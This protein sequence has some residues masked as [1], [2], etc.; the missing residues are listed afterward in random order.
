[1]DSS[2]FS[3]KHEEDE[4]IRLFR[5][6]YPDIYDFV[7]RLIDRVCDEQ[8]IRK[9]IEEYDKETF[10]DIKKMIVLR[11]DDEDT[12]R[13]KEEYPEEFY[14]AIRKM[15]HRKKKHPIPA[16]E[17]RKITTYK[18]GDFIEQKDEIFDVLGK[19]G[20]GNKRVR[21]DGIHEYEIEAIKEGGMGRVLILSRASDDFVD[22]FV[23]SLIKYTPRLADKLSLI[24]RGILAAKTFK[25]DVII[26]NNKALFE[27]ELNIWIN[28]NATNVAKLL[29]IVFINGKLFALMPYYSSN[30]R[31]I[32]KKGPL[33]IDDAKIIII[34]IIRGLYE[35]HKQYGI[36]HQDLKPEN[37]LISH[38]KDNTYFFV[39]DWGIAN[40]QKRY[41]PEFLSKELVNSYA[42]TMTGMG[43]LPYMSPERFIKYSS[44]MTAD[45]FSLGMIF[46]ELL[47][48]YLPYDLT[49]SNPLV[50]QI[51]N[52]DYFRLAEYK[53]RKNYNDKIADVILKC[54]HPDMSK[55]YTDYEKLV[56]DIYNVN[57]K[58]KFFIF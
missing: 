30:L 26:E 24:P 35:T 34:N 33:E 7:L 57:I 11:E 21:I 53:L 16:Q 41:C 44:H 27:C 9:F 32:I 4:D 58:R 3:N 23:E 51:I 14:N 6:E 15:V 5:E 22:P 28:I 48:G 10:D 45:V 43:T 55:R 42:E 46:Y 13:L 8:E 47:F 36:V 38:E 1:M 29:K 20:F 37:I 2:D 18:K 17:D 39:S 12:E 52:Q 19:G 49:S 50:S 40:L 25:D 56:M 31:E 54:I